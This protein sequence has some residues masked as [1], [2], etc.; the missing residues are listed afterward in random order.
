MG[1]PPN[2]QPRSESKSL[3]NKN[4]ENRCQPEERMKNRNKNE[5][6][7]KQTSSITPKSCEPN[8]KKPPQEIDTL[9]LLSQIANIHSVEKFEQLV[10]TAVIKDLEDNI[11][12]Q[13]DRKEGILILNQDRE[14][15]RGRE[16]Q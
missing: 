7:K 11:N 8:R 10:R 2:E 12:K 3:K 5:N 1:P 4:G 16:W 14:I 6:K 9:F 15:D 13:E